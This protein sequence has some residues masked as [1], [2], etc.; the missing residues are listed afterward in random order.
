MNIIKFIICQNFELSPQYFSMYVHVY[1]MYCVGGCTGVCI[2][3]EDVGWGMCV[4][5][6]TCICGCTRVGGYMC[7]H[8]FVGENM[9][10]CGVHVCACMWNL[11]VCFG[12]PRDHLVWFSQDP[13]QARVC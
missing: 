11:E 13:S 9:C 3:V 8:V 2:H 6:C 1:E 10:V 4:R 12:F 5:G 7:I